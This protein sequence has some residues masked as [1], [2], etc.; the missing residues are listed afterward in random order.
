MGG[1][2]KHV[3]IEVVHHTTYKSLLRIQCLTHGSSH[4][5]PWTTVGW[6][7][8]MLHGAD[9]IPANIDYRLCHA[10]R[11]LNMRMEVYK[12][13]IHMILLEL[14]RLNIPTTVQP[15]SITKCDMSAYMKMLKS[16]RTVSAIY[17]VLI[18]SREHVK[19][20]RNVTMT[21]YIARC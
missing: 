3:V 15:I 10:P 4:P 21:S 11:T 7:I 18:T 20:T 14:K 12:T 8:T 17:K 19:S 13:C 9:T 2:M 5:L 16:S 1:D 6:V